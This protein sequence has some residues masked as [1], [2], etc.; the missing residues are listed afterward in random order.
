MAML[1]I[2]PTKPLAG[3]MATSP[4]TAPVAVAIALG[5]LFSAQLNTI[6]VNAQA[7]AAVFVTTNALA[8]SGPAD[9]ALPALNPNQPNHSRA[10]PSRT[11]GTLLEGSALSAGPL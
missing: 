7:A 5:F 8:A 4:M 9:R 10:A 11:K 6:Q 1:A 2:G 3:V